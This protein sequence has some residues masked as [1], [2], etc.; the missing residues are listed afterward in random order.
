MKNIMVLLIALM[1]STTTVASELKVF[2]FAEQ[3]LIE[4]EAYFVDGDK[5]AHIDIQLLRHDQS[6]AW[7]QTDDQG[8]FF[9][10][11]L[12]PDAY[13]IRA[14]AGDGREAHYEISPEEMGLHLQSSI[15]A[16]ESEQGSLR[17]RFAEDSTTFD[18]QEPLAGMISEA[19]AQQLLPLQQ[20]LAKLTARNQRHDALA[21]VGY[22]LGFIGLISL[23]LSRFHNKT[24]VSV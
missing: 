7:T 5:A 10:R 12:T 8:V 6:V 1:A 4:G 2:A 13:L 17:E 18:A 24:S 14:Y 15:T 19:V 11:D 16:V 22:V 9:F 3:A 23:M 20:Q 21:S